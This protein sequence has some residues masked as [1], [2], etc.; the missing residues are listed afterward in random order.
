MAKAETIALARA[1]E[2]L[3]RFLGG[4]YV[5]EADAGQ[6]AAMKRMTFPE[7]AGDS[8]SDRDLREGYEL[9]RGYL[10]GFLDDAL[11][12][13][14]NGRKIGEVDRV[15]QGKLQPVGL[16]GDTGSAVRF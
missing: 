15:F 4:L 12:I 3:Y 7:I 9:L 11:V 1:R 5:M 10:A 8:D 13:L 2:D 6:L 16:V 14:K